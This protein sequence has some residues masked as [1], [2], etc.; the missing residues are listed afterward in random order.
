MFK[1]NN[2]DLKKVY[3]VL[4]KET[5]LFL[6]IKKLLESIGFTVYSEVLIKQTNRVVDIVGI[7]ET[8]N[9][10]IAVEIKLQSN[11]KLYE[12]AL[13]NASL[14]DF[15]FIALPKGRKPQQHELLGV[16]EVDIK[17]QIAY[18]VS[19]PQKF[20][21][22]KPTFE[23]LKQR[24]YL[25][26]IN[27]IIQGGVSSQK[28]LSSQTITEAKI[29]NFLIN[30]GPCSLDFLLDSIQTHYKNPKKSI[31]SLLKHQSRVLVYEESGVL[32]VKVNKEKN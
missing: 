28:G 7:N 21:S 24:L 4:M 32:M 5:D 26:S 10:S 30:Q 23:Q 16:I 1:Y 22:F 9:K 14:F 11:K 12:Q 29:I 27:Q 18:E 17:N 2:T 25:N 13:F 19:S 6:P 8:I 15:S 3:L 31:L 20:N